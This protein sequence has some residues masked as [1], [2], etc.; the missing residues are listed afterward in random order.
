MFAYLRGAVASTGSNHVVLDVS[1]IGF[2]INTSWQ[3]LSQ[4]PTPGEFCTLYTHFSVREDA[5]ELFGFLTE[6]ELECYEMLIAISGVGPRV[7]LAILSELSSEQFALAVATKDTK[8]LTLASGVG[9]KLAQ[10]IVMEL[11]DKLTGERF[12]SHEEGAAPVPTRPGDDADEAVTALV[13]R[14]YSQ[15]EALRAVR[16]IDP[17]GM[18]VEEIIKVALKSLMRQ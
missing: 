8:R 4:L 7:A 9:A 10:R 16:A 13:V 2:R 6:R 17:A 18:S 14:G 12:F 11:A 5:M 3:T 15:A 1:G